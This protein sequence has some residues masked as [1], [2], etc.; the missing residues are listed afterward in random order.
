MI[1]LLNR[2]GMMK[3][4]VQG[5]D[6]Q[7]TTLLPECLDDWVDGSNPVRAVDVFVDALELRELGFDGVTPAAT[8]RPGYHPSPMLKLY[9]FGYLNRVQS[10]R[11]LEREAGRNLEV[12][13]LTGRLVPDHKT[14][15]DF[16]KDNGPAIKKVCAQFVAL[17]RK[18]GLLEK[19]SVAIDGSKF[20]AVN[21]RDNNLTKGKMERRLAQIEEVRAVDAAG[22]DW[23]HLDVMDGH[24][25]PNI[26]YGPD[27]I[28]AMRPHSK[29]IF[30]AHL[31]ISPAD[32]YLEAFAK[33]GCD[34]IT[35]HAEAG[36]HLHRS[37]QAIRALGKKAGVSLNPGTPA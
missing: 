22:A 25:V 8:G 26:S 23:I 30:D 12:M 1:P 34:H 21:S 29:K 36:P 10:S 14:I 35:V 19:A 28:K 18:M 27:V 7:Q 11:R 3:G 20:K 4:F 33:A 32:P 6:R 37:L 13:W 15:A 31:M 5:A 9:I 16:R 24:F 2:G 17:C